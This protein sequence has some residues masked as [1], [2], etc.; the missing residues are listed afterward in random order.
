MDHLRTAPLVGI[1]G[2]VAV[3]AVLLAPYLLVDAAGGVG[4]YYGSGAITPWVAGLFALVSVIVFAA[5]REGR[6]DP[7]LA[8]GITLVLGVFT[9]AV[10]LA[11]A[12]TARVDAVAIVDYHRWLLVAAAALVPVGAGWF[13]RAL[14]LL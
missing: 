6:S 5:G 2:C 12:T 4:V 3:L 8:A 14:G 9:V 7:G 13:A 11:W 10:A 1:A